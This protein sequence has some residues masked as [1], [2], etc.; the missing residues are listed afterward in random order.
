MSEAGVPGMAVY[1]WYGL[2]GPAKMRREVVN[3][4]NSEVLKAIAVPAVRDRLIAA[5]ADPV[6]SGPAE[7]STHIRNEL[8]RWATVIQSAGIAAE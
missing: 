2:A 3:K 4:L 1:S 8:K 6:G 7:F 5:D